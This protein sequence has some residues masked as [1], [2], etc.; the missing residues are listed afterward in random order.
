ML[1][2]SPRLTFWRNYGPLYQP[3]LLRAQDHTAHLGHNLTYSVN[4]LYYVN[5][6]SAVLHLGNRTFPLRAGKIYIFPQTRDLHA[7]DAVNFDHTYFNDFHSRVLRYGS[8]T[9]IDG[10]APRLT[11]AT[12]AQRLNLSDSYLIRLFH[13]AIGVSPMQYI[14][15]CR[16]LYDKEQILRGE[17]VSTVV[18]MCGYG[19]PGAFCRAFRT[20]F[21]VSPTEM[22]KMY[23]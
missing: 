17:S 23:R 14:R 12:L 1:I 16:V 21:G 20:E 18:E 4:R 15:T 19:S 11:T 22:K 13:A 5:A 9:E 10:E 7:T 3:V 6:G 2:I 8:V